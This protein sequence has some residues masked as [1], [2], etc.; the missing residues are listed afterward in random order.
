MAEV[1]Y[2]GNSN[3]AK[4]QSLIRDAA[5]EKPVSAPDA[6]NYGAD[7]I[8]TRPIPQPRR[9]S[10]VKEVFAAILPGGFE[11]LKEHILWDV[12]VPFVQDMLHRGWDG[13]GEVLFPGSGGSKYRPPER[14]SYD[15]AY[16]DRVTYR[17]DDYWNVTGYGD[18]RPLRTEREARDILDYL[19]SMLARYGVVTLLDFN[20]RVGNPTNATQV[21]YG[22]RNLELARVERSRG[23]WVI[24]M[25]RAIPIDSAR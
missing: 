14:V 15:R 19:R 16:G 5:P 24:T 8:S 21:G 10:P 22:W 25:P 4:E 20:E 17:T 3:K 11:E 13:I 23:G 1:V 2:P 12:F 9:I 7:D 6:A 18:M